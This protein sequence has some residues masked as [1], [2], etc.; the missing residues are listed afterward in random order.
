MGLLAV[1][2]HTRSMSWNALVIEFS[3]WIGIIRSFKY[4]VQVCDCGCVGIEKS[5]I[6]TMLHLVN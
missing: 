1:F 5:K 4:S 6:T 2:P 3:L